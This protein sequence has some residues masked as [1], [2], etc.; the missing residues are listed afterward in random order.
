MDPIE[1]EITCTRAMMVHLWVKVRVIPVR[2]DVTHCL[3]VVF[4]SEDISTWQ[5]N[6]MGN[7]YRFRR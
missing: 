7:M 4:G 5:R 1:A 3:N 6:E 2:L